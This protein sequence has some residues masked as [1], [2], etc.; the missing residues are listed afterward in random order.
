MKRNDLLRRTLG[1]LR[2][3]TERAFREYQNPE[4]LLASELSLLEWGK[5]CLPTHFAKPP[6]KMHDWLSDRLDELSVSRGKKVNL[7]GPRGGAKSTIG[8]LAYVLRS[9]IE[10]REPYIWIVSDT[11]K[12]AA[13]HL[14]NIKTE[15]VENSQ[16]AELH[17]KVVGAGP[18]W[19]AAAIELRNGVVI[20]SFGTGQRIRGRRKRAHRP[21]LIVC[22]DLQN[23]SH[24]V[25]AVRRQSVKEWFH[26][27]LLKAGTKR[28]N[29]INLSTA[30]HRDDLAMQLEKTA[31]WRSKRFSSIIQWPKNMS[32]WEEW[33]AI[34]CDTAK[35]NSTEL[36]KQ[37]YRQ[38]RK[39]MH[40]DCELLWPE[41]EDLYT[42]M[43]M[44]LESG[45]STFE[46]EKQSS[47]IDPE[48]CEWPDSY[49]DAEV[50]FDDWPKELTLK[51]IALDPS[52]GRDSRQ[53]DYSA[54]ILLGVD[55]R[56][57]IYIEADLQRRPTSQM[58]ADG[59]EHYQRFRPDAFGVETNQWQQLLAAEFVSEFHRRG[60]V[61]VNPCEITNYV[62]KTMRIRR[63]GPYLS[64]RRFCFKRNSPGTELLIEQMKDFPLGQHDD[65][66][67]AL[68][69]A[70]RL[71]EETWRQK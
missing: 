48:L 38:H 21:T 6:S 57:R 42:L 8:T 25:S 32:L 31:G 55:A 52:K 17:G 49:F 41:E 23:D 9:A 10:E 71:A 13:A 11:K 33:E 65:G 58:V 7:I 45:H 62:N 36:A 59:V 19:N 22:D 39:A 4:T 43:C 18:R 27:T 60:L 14:E 12:Q 50:W 70:L 2:L 5:R 1:W 37:F 40:E 30:M 28:T 66:P 3:A 44:R 53:G 64:Q 47:P 63:L 69:M 46:R 54:I 15:L 67:D 68:E 29:I 20:E 51:T 34:Y 24:I 61:G 56:G 35:P 16:L 26:G